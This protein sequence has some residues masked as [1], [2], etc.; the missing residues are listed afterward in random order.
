VDFSGSLHQLFSLISSGGWKSRM[1]IIGKE[2]GYKQTALGHYVSTHKSSEKAD[3]AYDY[4]AHATVTGAGLLFVTKPK[5]Q[6]VPL[7]II[8]LVPTF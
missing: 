8:H 2:E 6:D 3:A 1:L 7:V 5:S 4:A